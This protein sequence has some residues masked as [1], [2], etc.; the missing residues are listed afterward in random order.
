MVKLMKKIID[1]EGI[2]CE[3]CVSTIQKAIKN[4]S[5]IIKVDVD[6]PKKKVI[7]EFNQSLKNSE[8]ILKKIKEAGFEIRM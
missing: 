4:L 7:V 8:E 6:I 2:T 5:G 3:H 1:V